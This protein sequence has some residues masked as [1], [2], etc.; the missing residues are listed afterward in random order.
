MNPPGFH[1]KA[2]AAGSA[3]A[4]FPTDA[5]FCDVFCAPRNKVLRTACWSLALQLMNPYIRL[6][7][8]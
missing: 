1:K 5:S 4:P 7:G 8:W 2:S 3:T 6:V